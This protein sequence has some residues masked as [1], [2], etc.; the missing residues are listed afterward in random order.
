MRM[1]SSITPRLAE[2]KLRAMPCC[3]KQL[4][5]LIVFRQALR[6]KL[7]LLPDA[8]NQKLCNFPGMAGAPALHAAF[9]RIRSP[10]RT[11]FVRWASSEMRHPMF[12]RRLQCDRDAGKVEQAS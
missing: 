8:L 12:E 6:L 1:R 4:L 7:V 5:H 10:N 11:S 9:G 3:K 2:P